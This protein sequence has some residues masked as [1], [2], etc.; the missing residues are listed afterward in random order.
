MAEV[1]SAAFIAEM[2][3][4]GGMTHQ[5]VLSFFE[6][7]KSVSLFD[8]KNKKVFLKRLVPNEHISA[9]QLYVGASVTIASRFVQAN[10]FVI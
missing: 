6:R 9:S 2:T 1:S 5:Y 10:V 3:D 8:I 4:L 7:D